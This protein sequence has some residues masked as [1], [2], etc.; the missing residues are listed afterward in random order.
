MGLIGYVVKRLNERNYINSRMYGNR[1]SDFYD[2][3]TTTSEIGSGG[4]GRCYDGPTTNIYI[5]HLVNFINH[6]EL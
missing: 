5:H 3:T 4:N 2:I 6:L 1:F